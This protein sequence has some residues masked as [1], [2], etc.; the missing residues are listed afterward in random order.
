MLLYLVAV[1]KGGEENVFEGTPEEM[2][3]AEMLT[4]KWLKDEVR[5]KST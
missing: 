2:V 3:D 4:A 1:K 5:E